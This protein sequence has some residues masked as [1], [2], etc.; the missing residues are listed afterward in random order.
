MKSTSSI[1]KSSIL[2]GFA[3]SIAAFCYVMPQGSIIGA[4]LFSFGLLTV[5]LYNFGLYTGQAGFF[6]TFDEYG[7]VM[8]VL[9]GNVI[10]CLLGACICVL[11]SIDNSVPSVFI[12]NALNARF[13]DNGIDA[14]KLIAK[15]VGCGFIMTVAVKLARTVKISQN[16]IYVLPLLLGVPI[17]LISGFFHSVVDA[18]YLS[19]GFISPN[20]SM[21]NAEMILLRICDWW[22]VVLGNL[23]GC[24]LIRIISWN[25]QI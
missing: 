8:L 18:F 3:I 15:A 14:I 12:E 23:L 11:S 10:G 4:L 25:K 24:N 22:L 21:G 2:G 9:L 13:A 16:F 7:D 6:Q 20:I 5:V 19:Y 17:F 1:L